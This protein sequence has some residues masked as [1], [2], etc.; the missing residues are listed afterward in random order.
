MIKQVLEH[1]YPNWVAPEDTGEEWISCLCPAH[2]DNNASAAISYEHDAFACLACGYKGDV[3]AI[4][5]R[6]EG[7]TFG[8]SKRIAERITGRSCEQVQNGLRGKPRR[9]VR[10][11]KRF[12][13]G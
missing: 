5:R 3:I 13:D 8:E 7:C 6:E 2:D 12:G 10:S 4:I 11:L 1:Y 9:R